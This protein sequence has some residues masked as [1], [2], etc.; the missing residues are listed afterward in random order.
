[1]TDD[2]KLASGHHII[3]K[4]HLHDPDIEA[5]RSRAVGLRESAARIR[6]ECQT[7]DDLSEEVKRSALSRSVEYDNE[8]ATIEKS[9]RSK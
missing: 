5:Q 8:A 6:R 3:T 4:M 7:R 2:R 9:L 1:M